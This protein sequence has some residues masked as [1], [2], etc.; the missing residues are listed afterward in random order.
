MAL[1]LSAD[2]GLKLKLNQVFDFFL[3]HHTANVKVQPN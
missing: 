3:G 1:T 2:S